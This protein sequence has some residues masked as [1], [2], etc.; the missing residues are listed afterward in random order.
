MGK[1]SRG[2]VFSVNTS[3]RAMWG[4]AFKNIYVKDTT[5]SATF[6]YKALAVT[7]GVVHW[8][9]RPMGKASPATYAGSMIFSKRSIAAWRKPQPLWQADQL[10][11]RRAVPCEQAALRRV[12]VSAWG[13]IHHSTFA[14]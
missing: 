12:V 13:R 9:I 5:Q 6:D 14:G 2:I 1:G 8:S 10:H 7:T 11:R 3:L 4:Q